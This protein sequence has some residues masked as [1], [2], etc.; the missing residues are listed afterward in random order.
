MIL[1]DTSVLIEFLRGSGSDKVKLFKEIL[2][3]KIPYGISAFTYQ[4]I[5]QGA[6]TETDFLTLKEYLLTQR[7]YY[8]GQE[9]RPYEQAARM[10][11]QLRRTGVTPRSTID[12]LIAITAIE[13]E[14]F[15][16][17]N[18]RDFDMMAEHISELKV[19]TA[20]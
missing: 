5:L 9:S 2:L 7:I 3:R 16:L 8:L 10:Y 14:L 15:L 6:R 19:Y 4:E 18:D 13:K 12:M 11:Y 17:H 20:L 1:V